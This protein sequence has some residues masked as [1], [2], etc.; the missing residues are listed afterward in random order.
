MPD[1]GH[2]KDEKFVKNVDLTNKGLKDN[3]VST[4][5]KLGSSEDTSANTAKKDILGSLNEN[6][7]K[8]EI[9]IGTV[10]NYGGELSINGGDNTK[11]DIEAGSATF[12]D[13]YT[14]PTNPTSITITWV[15]QTAVTVTDIGIQVVTFVGVNASGT[16]IQ[17][18]TGFSPSDER[19]IVTLGIVPHINLTNI[20]SPPRNFGNWG[21]DT[22]FDLAD[23]LSGLSPRINLGGNRFVANGANLNINRTLGSMF[24]LGIG[25]QDNKKNPNFVTNALEL[26]IGFSTVYRDANIAST[27]QVPN[28]QYDPNGDGSLVDIPVGYF[29][30]HRIYYDVSTGLA[31]LQ[32]GQ[33][34]YDSLKKASTSW[35]QEDFERD[36]ILA[37]TSL[38]TIIIIANGCTKLNDFDCAKFVYMGAYGE[39]TF[40]IV[41]NFSRFA[42]DIETSDGLSYQR[43][44]LS[45]VD[46]GGVLYADV[47]AE[48][49]F[50]A[51]DISFA[52]ADSSINTIGEDFTTA[53]LQVG[54]K[55]TITG[56]TNN[57][58]IF[59]VVTIA[60]LK[61]TV[62]E[63]ITDESAGSDITIVTPGKGNITYIFDQR[64]FI[65]DCTTGSGIGGRARIALTEGTDQSPQANWVY[66]VR[67][68]EISILQQSISEPEHAYSMLFSAFVPSVATSITDNF[69]NSRR[70]TDVKVVDGRGATAT[71]LSKLRDPNP[72]KSGAL[73][74]ITIDTGP[75][76]DSVDVT[77]AEGVFREIYLQN[78]NA[79]QLSVNGA[80]VIND[81]VTPYKKITDVNEIILDANG[82]S[83]NNRYFQVIFILS[84]NADGHIDRLLFNLPTGSYLSAQAAFD[85]TS[86]YSITTVPS[87]IKSAY[88][89]CAAVLRIQGGTTITNEAL[90]FGVNNIDLRGQELGVKSSGSGT[91]ATTQF[92]DASFTIFAN[93]DSS[94]ELAYDVSNISPVTKRTWTAPDRDLDLGNPLF[95]TIKTA[96]I[97]E[98]VPDAGINLEGLHYENDYINKSGSD[99]QGL[100]FDG[101]DNATLT[102]DLTVTGNLFVDGA[103]VAVDSRIST[104]DYILAMNFGEV[105]AGVTSGRCGIVT[106]RG[107]SDPYVNMFFEA[108]DDYRIGIYYATVNY[109]GKTGT[110]NLN[111]EIK[112][113]TSQ[114]TGYVIS[115]SGSALKLKIT[116]GTFVDTETIDNQT[117]T[118]SATVS[119]SP[120]ITNDT[121]AAAT[122]ENSP[123]DTALVFWNASATRF[124]TSANLTWGGSSLDVLGGG[125]FTL[126]TVHKISIGTPGGQTGI[127]F[128]STNLGDRSRFDMANVANA[129][130]SSRY[131]ALYYSA[132][133]IGSAINI[134]KG[135]NVGFG[136]S[137]ASA[138][139]DVSG[140]S[141]A[142]SN[143]VRLRAGD[144][145]NEQNVNQI[146]FS[147]NNTT[148]YTH[149][150]KTRHNSG[151]DIGNAIDFYVWDFGT[152]AS[153]DIGTKRVI[154]LENGVVDV[155]GIM[156]SDSMQV[157]TISEKTL[158]NGVVIEGINFKD[159][160]LS[161]TGEIDVVGHITVDGIILD[162]ERISCSV[163]DANLE[164][165]LTEVSGNPAFQF[166]SKT[167]PAQDMLFYST[168]ELLLDYDDAGNS[169]FGKLNIRGLDTSID[170][171]HITV[172][173]STDTSNPIYHQLNWN[174]DNITHVYGA[175]FG[176]TGWISS[177]AGSNLS[178]AK[179]NDEYRITYDSAV[180]VGNV[181]TWNDG[182]R[183][184][185]INGHIGL[186]AAPHASYQLYVPASGG[187]GCQKIYGTSDITVS[188]SDG[189]DYL[190][191]DNS[192][193]KLYLNGTG[194][195]YANTVYGVAATGGTLVYINSAGLLGTNAS[196]RESKIN[197]EDFNTSFFYD[198]NPKKFNYRKM[199]KD[200]NYLETYHDDVEY[201]LIAD[202]VELIESDLV[203]YENETKEKVVGL[204]YHLLIPILVKVVQEQKKTID[205]LITR[206]DLL[207]EQI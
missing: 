39:K 81:S 143:A 92:S 64:E 178:T 80:L 18:G 96:Q 132:D 142:T 161:M 42:E 32:Y 13:N 155:N 100:T 150:I 117:V 62:S 131:F 203:C 58:G 36:A 196:T 26:A 27:N 20:T 21:R 112:G 35:E 38:R 93:A 106:D 82:V 10:F 22:K 70:W 174:S 69:V 87:G 185:L 144:S 173:T 146:L 57:N 202:D 45:Y 125:T 56:S 49:D 24:G 152:D 7:L 176:A 110:F 113:F 90:G 179:V 121:Q 88:L 166:N 149:A 157:D 165:S 122:R 65:L 97:S 98:L 147:H 61:I 73:P 153:V 204:K 206:V 164:F 55:I 201:G 162:G 108:N 114:A 191:I 99:S 85:D 103:K 15:K 139:I 190:F 134:R 160:D 34:V 102:K 141:T 175:Y 44:A 16:F 172:Y 145:A 1:L 78:T 135:G 177:D 133:L 75:S 119:G 124:D 68:G 182:L 168:G 126:S 71:I 137:Q 130:V 67:S 46:S 167:T 200:K 129:T 116:K 11:F 195:V 30:S 193:S 148:L 104:S 74:T 136:L 91:A 194:G 101:S 192:T 186:G 4:P 28:S 127:L 41:D 128:N 187:I 109:I 53:N 23:M 17:N 54:D 59:T 105:G 79:L 37:N 47:A 197:I 183:M 140:S 159:N 63:T 52:N 120:V 158:N 2:N 169:G 86:G 189:T 115:D 51:D 12:V 207:A 171:P 170:G 76:P 84:L 3:N 8:K 5:V 33:F 50:H 95:D 111:D 48:F 43:Q 107:T 60:T 72:Y 14:D 29:T 181:I 40:N 83:L 118:G 89:L 188:G 66:V 180:T 205:D 198:L 184:N 154:S 163:A 123:I 77:V 31:A 19:E 25:Y 6:K 138:R 151:A 9:A 199:D 94:K 156:Q